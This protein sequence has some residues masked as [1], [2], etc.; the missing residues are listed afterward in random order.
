MRITVEGKFGESKRRYTLDKIGTNLK[1]TRET[2]IMIVFLVMKL[3]VLARRKANVFL[4]LLID[5][6]IEIIKRIN[7]IP[8]ALFRAA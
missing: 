3:M 7:I 6:I 2:S 8:L 1:Q 5:M 4:L